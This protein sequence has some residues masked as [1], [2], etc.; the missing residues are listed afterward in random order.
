M[1]K[2][3]QT[4]SFHDLDGTQKVLSQTLVSA[5]Q[6]DRDA[7][8]AIAAQQDNIRTLTLLESEATRLHTTSEARTTRRLVIESSTQAG[9]RSDANHEETRELVSSQ[10]NDIVAHIVQSRQEL[11]AHIDDTAQIQTRQ[12]QRD[13]AQNQVDS[14]IVLELHVRRLQEDAASELDIANF[15]TD[16]QIK[17]ITDEAIESIGAQLSRTQL[18]LR[19][20][21]LLQ[22]RQRIEQS[23]SVHHAS[24]ES[25]EEVPVDAIGG[26]ADPTH[27]VVPAST[28]YDT[29]VSGTDTLKSI[30]KVPT[31]KQV[32]TIHTAQQPLR[33]HLP[34][35]RSAD[36]N[37]PYNTLYVWNLPL[38]T[39]K[40][41]L[42]ALFSKQRGYKQLY[43]R[44]KQNGLMRLAEFE[45]ISFATRALNE[46]DG[47]QLHNSLKGGIR[48]SFSKK[49]G[50][51][52]GY[53]STEPPTPRTQPDAKIATS[54]AAAGGAKSS[55]SERSDKSM[56][57]V[58]CWL[59]SEGIDLTVLASYLKEYIDD[60]ATIKQSSNPSDASRR[61]FTI[62]ASATVDISGL[63][64]LIR[65]SKLW[66]A[67]Q[68]TSE[69]RR[70]PYSYMDSDTWH[71][72]KRAG[73]TPGYKHQP[74]EQ[75]SAGGGTGYWQ[76]NSKV[77]L[78]NLSQAYPRHD[79]RSYSYRRART[80]PP[81]KAMLCRS[82]I[83][84]R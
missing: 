60:A 51:H 84:R 58:Q 36:R 31:P 46:L 52:A 64:D 80:D 76:S 34:P 40:D 39:S 2:L 70:N 19:D 59:P 62:S 50:M 67:E 11:E 3:Q 24:V 48:L 6:A 53:T 10:T 43:F 14:Q 33:Q 18:E 26:T 37:P 55:K 71:S 79:E 7:F 9:E 27:G 15:V 25:K 38:D 75:S 30:H 35:V 68:K 1:L 20:L 21:Q 77:Q 32:S 23:Y 74:P 16:W 61:G 73:P 72:R 5:L 8:D 63:R 83:Q 4:Q 22:V 57:H 78:A 82:T 12:L 42:R 44:E 69:Y 65:D 47:V 13:I 28:T 45:D 41:E 17:S 56:T 81:L 49:P 66:A 29:R 54:K